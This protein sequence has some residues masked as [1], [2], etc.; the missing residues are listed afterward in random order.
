MALRA[1]IRAARARLS[2]RRGG[3]AALLGMGLVPYVGFG[4]GAGAGAQILMKM[5]RGGGDPNK[6][7]GFIRDNWWGEPLALLLGA[8][9]LKRRMPNVSHSILGAA[10]YA[11]AFNYELDKF[12]KGQGSTP[13]PSF[14]Q[15]SGGATQALGEG[16]AGA[17]FNAGAVQD[18]T[19]F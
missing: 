19:T 6:G 1:R 18:A 14:K 3:R 13:V 11:G 10:G 5:A 9:L 2:K 7:I 16:D 4:A 15:G 17:V 12:Q 8:I